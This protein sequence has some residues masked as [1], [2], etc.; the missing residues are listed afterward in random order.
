ML[1]KKYFYKLYLGCKRGMLE[2][3]I[4]LINYLEII[5]LRSDYIFLKKFNRLLK[6]SDEKLYNWI[7]KGVICEDIY[8]VDLIVNIN[9]FRQYVKFV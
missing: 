5:C 4:I 8:F 1:E 7:I 3:D 6:E 9:K 2:L